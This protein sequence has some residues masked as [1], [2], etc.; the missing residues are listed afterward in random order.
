ML[1]SRKP[2]FPQFRQFMGMWRGAIGTLEPREEA[3]LM[4]MTLIKMP[5]TKDIVDIIQKHACI[6]V[7]EQD[8]LT[9]DSSQKSDKEAVDIEPSR[10]FCCCFWPPK[11][12]NYKAFVA[13]VVLVAMMALVALVALVVIYRT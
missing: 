8:P 7:G 3:R 9:G 4:I 10:V 11:C 12:G 6:H 1:R 13:L 5:L 2:L